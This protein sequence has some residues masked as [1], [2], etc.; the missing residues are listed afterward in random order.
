MEAL[1][2]SY[3][4]LG[5][6]VLPSLVF[7]TLG[8]HSYRHT[9]RIQWKCCTES[10]GSYHRNYR[11]ERKHQEEQEIQEDQEYVGGTSHMS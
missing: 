4:F 3:F 10:L 7:R 11:L 8:F 2:K 9:S 5:R 6:Q 1:I